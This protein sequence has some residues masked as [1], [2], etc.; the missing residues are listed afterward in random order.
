M[1]GMQRITKKDVCPVQDEWEQM[2]TSKGLGKGFKMRRIAE[3][4][5]LGV[6]RMTTFF[7]HAT[8]FFN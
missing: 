6:V 7:E 4:E 2:E 3:R 5:L 8:C 1:H